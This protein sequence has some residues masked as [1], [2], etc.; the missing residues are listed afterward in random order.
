MEAV[1]EYQRK[2]GKYI[3]PA[4]VYFRVVWLIRDYYRMKEM[5]QA[6]LD[7]SPAPSD[8]MPHGSPNPDGVFNK[9]SRRMYFTMVC[10]LIDREIERV[11]RE[12]RRGVWNNILYKAA[13]PNDAGRSTY[14]MYKS[15]TIYNIAEKMGL[16]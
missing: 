11:P 1:K 7:E 9:A 16:I 14:A 3:L 5:A 13:Y 10:D 12:Y 8:G 6:I 15:R 2:K 4:A